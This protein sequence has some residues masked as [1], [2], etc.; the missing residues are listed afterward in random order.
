MLRRPG[1]GRN[2]GG[3]ESQV[4][5]PMMTGQPSVVRLKCA[6]SSGRCQG[7]VP[8]LPMTPLAARAKIRW[9]WG[10]GHVMDCRGWRLSRAGEH[11]GDGGHHAEHGQAI[12]PVRPFADDQVALRVPIIGIAITLIALVDGGRSRAR[13]NQISWAKP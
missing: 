9:S 7:S 8:F 11:G 4:L 6:R 13:P 10:R 3:S 2:L 1:S 5:R 12:L